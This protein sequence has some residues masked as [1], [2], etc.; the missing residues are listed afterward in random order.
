MTIKIPIAADFDG[1][2]VEAQ[3]QAFRQQLN[4]LGTQIAAANKVKFDPVGKTS[5]E[6]MRKMIGQFEALK[7]VSGDMNK[8]INATGQ[9]GANFTDLDWAKLYPDQNSRH[10]QMQKAFQYVTGS[11]FG[12]NAAPAPP[13]IRP[14]NAPPPPQGP[15]NGGGGGRGPGMGAGI[16][17]AGLRAAGPVGGVAANAMGTGMSAG[18]G[19]G[20]M[21]LL[22][23]IGALAI[24]KVVSSVTEKMG[25][26]EDNLVAFDKLK[27]VLGDVNVSFVGLKSVLEGS[28]RQVGVTFSEAG[29]LASQFA[30][31][32]NLQGN[33]FGTLAGE[34]S[35]GVGMSRSL[36]L[37]PSQ[38]VGF[39]GS[40]RGMKATQDEQG[41]RKMALLV[42]ETI[43]KSG[44]FAKADEVMGAISGYVTSQTRASLSA[45]A[46]GFSGMFSSMVGS[47]IP[48]MDPTGAAGILSKINSSLSAGGAKGEASQFFSAGVGRSMGLDPVQTQILREGGAFATNDNTFGKGSV[49]SRFGVKGPSGSKTWMQGSIERLKAQ[50]GSNPGLL[51]EATANHFGIGVRQAMGVLSIDPSKMGELEG[52]LSK[53]GVN[54]K[55]MNFAGLGSLAK[56]VSGSSSDRMGVASELWSRTG[57]DKLDAAESSKLDNVM[58]SGSEQEQKEVLT[59]LIASRDQEMTQGKDIRDTKVGVDNIKTLLAEQ[60][61]PVT[62]AMRDGIMYMAG[63]GKKSGREIQLDLMGVEHRENANGIIRNSEY[64]KLSDR[65]DELQARTSASEDAIRMTYRDKPAIMEAK[66]KERADNLA[67]MAEI[68]KKLVAAKAHQAD[69]LEKENKAY[70]ERKAG[71]DKQTESFTPGNRAT[72]EGWRAPGGGG[73]GGG[74]ADAGGGAGGGRTAYGDAP[75]GASDAGGGDFGA[76]AAMEGLS[77]DEARLARSIYT[78]ES[79][80]G[81]DTRTSHAGAAGHMQ[82]MPATFNQFADPGWDIRNPSH[83][84]RAAMRYIKHL[85][86]VSGGNI[87]STAGGYY[88]GEG[89]I[90]ADGSLK[91]FRDKKNSSFP[92]TQEYA[93]QVMKRMRNMPEGTPLPQGGGGKEQSQERFIFDSQPIEVIHKNE[94]GEQVRAPAQLATRIRPATP[95]GADRAIA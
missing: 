75:A 27:R 10:R 4:A 42:G 14:P 71:L 35:T 51:A 52:Q 6:D 26:A 17:Q 46:S 5:I 7:R 95:F 41:S 58:K 78:Q 12:T 80:G 65:R 54:L 76:E 49:A 30:K 64:G 93:D 66:L 45:N 82:M 73:G 79:A 28:A 3:L 81:K 32:G 36:G 44:A 85:N 92:N 15:N 23:G 37:D 86:K 50:Y 94:R 62:Q 24:G 90:R 43:A 67:E 84:R 48:G 8:R 56:V 33:Q 69:L 22:G 91:T 89:A 68:D 55:D 34:L 57:K 13:G 59:Q 87:R 47:G 11:A 21:G 20:M 74:G 61:L 18:F 53:S 39:L 31:S 63:G 83:N 70:E 1:S 2:K 60:L 40:M 38:G 9:K 16:A 72:P 19:A 25:Q 29:Q 77:N 88:G